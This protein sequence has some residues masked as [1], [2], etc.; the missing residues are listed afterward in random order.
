MIEAI[1]ITYGIGGIA[2]GLVIGFILSRLM[3][4]KKSLEQLRELVKRGHDN[5]QETNEIFRKLYTAFN[6]V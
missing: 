6:E 4:R 5:L 2:I 1:N 3:R